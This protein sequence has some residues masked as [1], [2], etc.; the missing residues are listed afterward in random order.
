MLFFFLPPAYEVVMC[1]MCSA[2]ACPQMLWQ[3][4]L[5]TDAQSVS[6]QASIAI[7]ALNCCHRAARTIVSINCSAIP[8]IPFRF[9]SSPCYPQKRS[10]SPPVSTIF[11]SSVT[12][13]AQCEY[14]SESAHHMK[15]CFLALFSPAL[16]PFWRVSSKQRSQQLIKI[17]GVPGYRSNFDLLFKEELHY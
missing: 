11:C 5:G 4:S 12:V 1:E 9:F 17:D 8:G 7:A 10:E 15:R 2:L 14:A 16:P 13:F 6:G 3:E